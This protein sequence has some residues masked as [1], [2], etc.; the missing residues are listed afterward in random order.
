MA[1]DSE[2][3]RR[4]IRFADS[5]KDMMGNVEFT[6]EALCTLVDTAKKMT[7]VELSD[8]EEE[9]IFKELEYKYQIRVTPG[10]CLLADYNQATWYTDKKSEINPRFWNRYKDYL[11]DEKYF[12]PNVISTLGDDTLDLSLMNC[13]GNPDSEKPFLKRGLII[14]DVQ[15]GKTSTYIGLMCKAADAGYKVFILLTD[16]K[17]V[18]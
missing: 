17:S 11:I 14:G 13:L 8:D 6:E 12:N 4:F 18:V 9:I 1:T 7:N 3:I 2:K 10:E 16:R 15:S 5:Y